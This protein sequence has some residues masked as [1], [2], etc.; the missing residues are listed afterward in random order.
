MDRDKII[1]REGEVFALA[2]ACFQ[3][4]KAFME[5]K[6]RM[7]AKKRQ[8]ERERYSQPRL[9]EDGVHGA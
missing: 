7:K 6:E 5:W 3:G 2:I 9:E 8:Q 1:E 4:R